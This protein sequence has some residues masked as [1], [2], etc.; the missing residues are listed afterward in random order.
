MGL[1]D[2][3][4][5]KTY[6]RTRYEKS[7][8]QKITHDV[9]LVTDFDILF[10]GDF[11]MAK[12]GDDGIWT[13]LHTN[14]IM[15]MHRLT[16]THLEKDVKIRE[17]VLLATYTENRS[18]YLIQKKGTHEERQKNCLTSDEI[19]ARGPFDT[20]K[21]VSK[22][23]DNRVHRTSIY[24][25]WKYKQQFA[26][27][28]RQLCLDVSCGLMSKTIGIEKIHFVGFDGTYSWIEKGGA[29]GTE[30]MTGAGE[31]DLHFYHFS[32]FVTLQEKYCIWFQSTDTDEFP[33]AA[34][35][36]TAWKFEH[37]F[38]FDNGLYERAKGENH[39]AKYLI[40]D[41]KRARD[42]NSVN[43]HLFGFCCVLIGTDFSE[44]IVR[45]PDGSMQTLMSDVLREHRASALSLQ[46]FIFSKIA[47]RPTKRP[48]SQKCPQPQNLSPSNGCLLTATDAASSLFPAETNLNSVSDVMWNL[49]YW[50]IE[51]S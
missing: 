26:E 20:W 31:A 11:N 10:N 17:L 51:Y 33:I 46:D 3:P 32:A 47:R 18:G 15:Y 13:R 38:F 21:H 34:V 39:P 1:K 14:L 12:V 19:A 9:A 44:T 35:L 5:V 49:A 8:E 2:K 50:H 37:G 24:K 42:D 22:D 45:V 4:P 36:P 23:D 41:M 43:W 27:I 48:R 6:M 40:V 7:A 28:R 29:N 30:I 16:E 25:A